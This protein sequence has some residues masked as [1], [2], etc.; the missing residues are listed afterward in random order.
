MPTA[1]KMAPVGESRQVMDLV[2]RQRLIL[3]RAGGENILRIMGRD[4]RVSVSIHVTAEGPVLKLEGAD[5]TIR[6]TGDL[7]V[8]A[9]RLTLH[10]RSGVVLSSGGD[11]AIRIERDLDVSARAQN[12]RAELGDI[13]LRAN[14]DIRMD[15]ERIRH[16]C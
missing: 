8:E 11:A 9:E 5:L 3:E 2:G 15:G 4:G 14:D 7:A 16:N 6:S 10:G 12:I 1:G 13:R